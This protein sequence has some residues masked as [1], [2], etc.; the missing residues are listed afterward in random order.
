MLWPTAFIFAASKSPMICRVAPL[1][2]NEGLYEKYMA[3]YYFNH[4]YGNLFECHK[5]VHGKKIKKLDMDDYN[6]IDAASKSG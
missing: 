1:S 4:G 6:T 3:F 2:N 5:L